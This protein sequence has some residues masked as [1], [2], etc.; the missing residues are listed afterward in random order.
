MKIIKQILKELV[1]LYDLNLVP[2]ICTFDS[3]SVK[4]KLRLLLLILLLLLLLLLLD[5]RVFRDTWYP[6]KKWAYR[7]IQTT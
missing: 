2:E 5:K 7:E 3:F 4:L 6:L 1:D